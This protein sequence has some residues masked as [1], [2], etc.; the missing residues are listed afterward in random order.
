MRSGESQYTTSWRVGASS[1][2]ASDRLHCHG[3]QE[4]CRSR[5]RHHR[6]K[7]AVPQWYRVYLS[8]FEARQNTADTPTMTSHLTNPAP[9]SSNCLGGSD[10][11]LLARPSTVTDAPPMTCMYQT[12]E[13]DRTTRAG[14]ARSVCLSEDIAHTPPHLASV[15]AMPAAG[16]T[17]A[18]SVGIPLDDG[19]C[20][21]AVI[22]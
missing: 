14:S 12:T 8:M 4:S 17:L 2:D 9:L 15:L 11:H 1:Y 16:P 10:D 6:S 18:V 7:A 19:R 13:S 22:N 5:C 21:S 20:R 3:R